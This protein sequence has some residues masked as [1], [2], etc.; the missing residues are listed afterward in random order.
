VSIGTVLDV[1][2]T[3]FT[4][5]YPRFLARTIAEAAMAPFS[6]IAITHFRLRDASAAPPPA[7]DA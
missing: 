3:L 7:A 1:T 4:R 2:W 5:F 6:A